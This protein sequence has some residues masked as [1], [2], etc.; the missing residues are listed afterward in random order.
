MKSGLGFG[1]FLITYKEFSPSVS[2]TI[3]TITF[4][5]VKSQSLFISNLN[6]CLVC[7]LSIYFIKHLAHK[8]FLKSLVEKK[9]LVLYIHDFPYLNS[10]DN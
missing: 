8:T 2:K 9:A 5:K 1:F 10:T 4:T 3:S 6:N 7:A